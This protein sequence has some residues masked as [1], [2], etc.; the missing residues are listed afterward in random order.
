MT[1]KTSEVSY[2]A[3]I[4][5]YIEQS[6]MDDKIDYTKQ[7][8][9]GGGTNQLSDVVSPSIY[10]CPSWD[11]REELAYKGQSSSDYNID[12]LIAHHYEAVMGGKTGVC[13]SNQADPYTVT[14]HPRKLGACGTEGGFASNGVMYCESKTKFGQITDGS[15]N[16]FLI[17]EMSW[18]ACVF[19]S[20]FVGNSNAADWAFGGKNILYPLNS[21]TSSH[22][23]SLGEFVRP[24]TAL[25]NDTSFGSQ[26]VGGVHFAFADG[27][28]RFLNETI[29]LK[30]LRA[31]ASRAVDEVV[32][33]PW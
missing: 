29:E 26:H 11:G 24:G 19:R 4:L 3:L 9:N 15:S 8:Q 31:F 23:L 18:N 2:H 17:G 6:Q 20:W 32:S 13:P 30:T 25:H 1:E 33:E 12:P 22:N 10:R 28:V 21:E 14:S 16:T 5:P 27:S 7:W